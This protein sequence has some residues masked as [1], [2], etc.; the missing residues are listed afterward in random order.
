[1][2]L[3]ILVLVLGPLNDE[4]EIETNAL[5]NN[6]GIFTCVTVLFLCI[7]H[8]ACP[9]CRAAI[10]ILRFIDIRDP[11]DVIVHLGHT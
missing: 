3:V 10:S 5:T 9:E 6:S 4:I 2:H 1:M 8:I 7:A 11:I